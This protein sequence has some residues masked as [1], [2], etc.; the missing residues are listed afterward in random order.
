M[1]MR[2]NPGVSIVGGKL[3]QGSQPALLHAAYGAMNRIG[4]AWEGGLGDRAD[5][6]SEPRRCLWMLTAALLVRRSLLDQMGG[7]DEEMFFGLEDTDFCWRA[8][9]AGHGVM[10]N[11][12]SV[13]VHLLNQTIDPRRALRRA[14]HLI[15]R[16]RIRMLLQ[17]YEP[18]S[19]WR[20]LPTY[21]ALAVADAVVFGPRG[22]KWSA[23]WWNVSNIRST[24][25]RRRQVQAL[26]RVSDTALFPLFGRGLR[27]PGYDLA[28]YRTFEDTSRGSGRTHAEA[29]GSATKGAS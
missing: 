20:Y 24:L 7:F 19:L 14:V 25:R 3:L 1:A 28:R 6:H 27:G 11:P 21:L 4:V 17:N 8:S 13:A 23:F 29:L 18:T 5:A 2:A 15:R 16:N 10:F 12:E 26:R 9:L 22:P